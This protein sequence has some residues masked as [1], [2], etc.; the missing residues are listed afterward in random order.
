MRNARAAG[1]R[2]RVS[3]TPLPTWTLKSLAL[4]YNPLALPA[5]RLQTTG[6]GRKRGSRP[7]LTLSSAQM[8]WMLKPLLPVQQPAESAPLQHDGQRQSERQCGLPRTRGLQ[9][10]TLHRPPA[11]CLMA[12]ALESGRI[13]IAVRARA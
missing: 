6:L 10:M 13:A 2:S 12:T 1:A 3:F 7:A 5:S 11:I 8:N 4:L 9:A